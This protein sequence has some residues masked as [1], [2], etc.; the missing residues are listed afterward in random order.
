M[1]CHNDVRQD[2]DDNMEI[3]IVNI[4]IICYSENHRDNYGK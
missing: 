2:G 4:V 3:D 1:P